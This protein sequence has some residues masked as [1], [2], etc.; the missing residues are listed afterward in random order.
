MGEYTENPLYIV[1]INDSK[2]GKEHDFPITFL[3]YGDRLASG[4]RIL[5]TFSDLHS[6]I[7]WEKNDDEFDDI[8]MSR[9]GTD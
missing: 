8:A 5:K 1:V 2:V 3:L 4:E 6:L 7:D 9:G